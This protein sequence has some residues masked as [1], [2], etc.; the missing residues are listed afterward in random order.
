MASGDAGR[1]LG[2]ARVNRGA[3]SL[4]TE[5]P[6]GRGAGLRRVGTSGIAAGAATTPWRRVEQAAAHRPGAWTAS[7]V[8][9][10]REQRAAAVLFPTCR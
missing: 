3:A 10:G 6:Y 5:L 9:S 4:R 2:T 8:V 7:R 1:I